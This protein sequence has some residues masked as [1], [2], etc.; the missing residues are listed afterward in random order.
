MSLGLKGPM[1]RERAV[2]YAVA[3]TISISG[4]PNRNKAYCKLCGEAL[5]SGIG[6]GAVIRDEIGS[7]GS[8]CYLC[9]LC[10]GWVVE[11]LHR[12]VDFKNSKG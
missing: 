11:H 6:Q 12:W 9:A 1:T 2:D 7:Q 4:R 3:S 10:A 5:S 8:A